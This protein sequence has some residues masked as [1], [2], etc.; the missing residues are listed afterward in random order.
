MAEET[1]TI[2]VKT[3]ASLREA[4]SSPSVKIDL[5]VSSTILEVL[6]KLSTKYGLKAKN[7]LFPNGE[8]DTS[9]NFLVNQKP[10]KPTVE[11]LSNYEL[12][13][14]DVLLIIPMVGGG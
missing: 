2:T 10:I 13:N 7:L 3:F 5:S 9:F 12:K 14:G 11:R 4:L 8:L 1:I 6:N